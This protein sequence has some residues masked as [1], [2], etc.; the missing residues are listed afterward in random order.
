[1]KTLKFGLAPLLSLFLFF[2][3]DVEYV[4]PKGGSDTNDPSQNGTGQLNDGTNNGTNDGTNNQTPETIVVPLQDLPLFYMDVEVQ[5]NGTVNA[6]SALRAN[7]EVDP[8]TFQNDTTLTLRMDA[9]LNNLA[10]VSGQLSELRMKSEITQVAIRAVGLHDPYMDGRV[11]YISIIMN[12]LSGPKGGFGLGACLPYYALKTTHVADTT[13][14]NCD[15]ENR[16]IVEIFN[17]AL[18]EFWAGRSVYFEAKGT[19]TVPP[20]TKLRYYFTVNGSISFDM[21]LRQ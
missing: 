19:T 17:G 20:H 12:Y 6:V 2:A 16:R 7:T 9:I 11:S 18:D 5:E 21:P 13:D 4:E 8:Y 3:C 14:P 1:M 10:A 15:F